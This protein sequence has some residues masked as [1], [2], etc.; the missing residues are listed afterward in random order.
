[1]G[2]EKRRHYI[3]LKGPTALLALQQVDFVAFDFLAAK[4]P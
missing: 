1:M 2:Q 3:I 4:G